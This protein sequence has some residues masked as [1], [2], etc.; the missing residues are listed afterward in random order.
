MQRYSI[1]GTFV[2]GIKACFQ[3]VQYAINEVIND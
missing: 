1:I 2:L 3:A